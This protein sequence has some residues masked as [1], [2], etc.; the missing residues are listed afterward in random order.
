VTL[1]APAAA[2]QEGKKLTVVVATIE[3][4]QPGTATF[5][6]LVPLSGDKELMPTD[7]FLVPTAPPWQFPWRAFFLGLLTALL[8]SV[9]W[10]RHKSRKASRS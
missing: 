6:R 1:S 5:W 2:E 9:L 10:L 8:V 4:L 3:G 7:E